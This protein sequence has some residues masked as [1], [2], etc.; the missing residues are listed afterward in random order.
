M[1]QENEE[2][3]IGGDT[4]H[5]MGQSIKHA[6]NR[7]ND[8]KAREEKKSV[9]MSERGCTNCRN[10]GVECECQRCHTQK[11]GCC[12]C[13]GSEYVAKESGCQCK[14]HT[15]KTVGGSGISVTPSKHHFGEIAPTAEEGWEKEFEANRP[16]TDDKLLGKKKHSEE[17]FFGYK[18]IWEGS[19][20]IHEV[21]DW[22][23]IKDFISKAIADS[24]KRGRG[25]G[26][27]EGAAEENKRVVKI[28]NDYFYNLVMVPMPEK[29]GAN[30]IQII[31]T[32]DTPQ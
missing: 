31:R 12:M 6:M 1:T 32:K 25:A 28:I 20:Q 4:R 5:E 22:G 29:T 24:Y 17:Y 30:L 21:T 3:Y 23:R 16:R 13:F 11:T 7:A 2:A 27:A 14:C 9:P 26:R 8:E 18:Y 10:C 19:N 15:Q